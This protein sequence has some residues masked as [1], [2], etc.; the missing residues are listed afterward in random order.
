M[1]LKCSLRGTKIQWWLLRTTARQYVSAAEDI[2]L[3]TTSDIQKALFS[4]KN[5]IVFLCSGQLSQSSHDFSYV[6]KDHQTH[7]EDVQFRASSLGALGC[8]ADDLYLILVS[9]KKQIFLLK[10]ST[11]NVWSFEEDFL[12]QLCATLPWRS[13]LSL[14]GYAPCFIFLLHV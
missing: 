11:E 4:L 14:W 12:C 9:L 2:L 5:F 1:L 8:P 6:S 7:P 3:L 13:L 10:G